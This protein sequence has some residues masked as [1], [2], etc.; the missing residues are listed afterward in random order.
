MFAQN[1]QHELHMF[2]ASQSRPIFIDTDED[3][4]ASSHVPTVASISKLPT[5]EPDNK[6]TKILYSKFLVKGV[7]PLNCDLMLSKVK[8]GANGQEDAKA[9]R[10][11][12]CIN[13]KHGSTERTNTHE[14]HKFEENREREKGIFE[15][16]V[17]RN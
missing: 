11:G 4:K 5:F 14:R 12:S 8:K 15:Y 13:K 6:L 9:N 16:S 10:Q 3:H 1:K 7:R 2:V 17:N